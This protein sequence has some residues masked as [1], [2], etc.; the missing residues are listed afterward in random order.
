MKEKISRSNFLK[1][2]AVLT[3]GATVLATGIGV[4]IPKSSKANTNTEWPWPYV[5]L[6]PEQARIR[7]HDDFW[8]GKAC[9][10]G[11][12]NGVISLLKDAVG[13]PYDT[14]PTELMIY[15]HGG[16]AGWGATCGTINGGAA[17]ISLVCSKEDSDILVNELFGWYTQ[18]EFPTDISND[19][20]VNHIFTVEKYDGVLVQNESGS[21]MCHTSVTKWCNAADIAVDAIERKERCAR[22][23][24]DVAAKVVELLNDHY[25]GT[26][27][28]GYVPP[29]SIGACMACHGSTGSQHNVA[30]KQECTSCHG[31]D[32]HASAVFE[33]QF[34]GFQ[35]NQNFPNPFDRKTTI[36]FN[37]A[38]PKKITII[39][40]N[41]NGEHIKTLISNKA[42]SSGTHSVVWNGTSEYGENASEGMY[43]YRFSDGE[44]MKSMSMM[45]VK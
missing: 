17:V 42:Y 34:T 29:A 39:V 28:P 36:E 27:V 45:K 6:D 40:Y 9:C 8:S 10:Y 41:I 21:P 1:R 37:L 20:A 31:E 13:T 2:T 38:H 4:M 16:G 22:S 25:A 33:G 23:A 14:F 19:Y 24:G 3:T 11:V 5:A 15:G 44:N 7:A 26:F 35:L 18:T 43:I 32:P 30:A 12:F